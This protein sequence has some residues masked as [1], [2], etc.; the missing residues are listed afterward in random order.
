MGSV[1]SPGMNAGELACATGARHD[2][3][4]ESATIEA[5]NDMWKNN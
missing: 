5:M 3:A 1:R 4:T 2:G